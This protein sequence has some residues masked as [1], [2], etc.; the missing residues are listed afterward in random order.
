MPLQENDFDA[1]SLKP[2]TSRP[3]NSEAKPAI[4]SQPPPPNARNLYNE[5]AGIYQRFVQ[6]KEFFAFWPTQPLPW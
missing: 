6:H 1:V 5:S 2:V 3:N 4:D